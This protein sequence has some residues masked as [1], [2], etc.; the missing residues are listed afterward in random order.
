M[1][2]LSRQ[3][4]V[5]GSQ[6]AGL[7]DESLDRGKGERVGGPRNKHHL[8]WDCALLQS[9][10]APV[11]LSSLFIGISHCPHC[12]SLM[13]WHFPHNTCSTHAGGDIAA[14]AAQPPGAPPKGQGRPPVGT[15]VAWFR[16]YGGQRA[17]QAVDRWHSLGM[18]L[19][20]P[21]GSARRDSLP[22][23]FVGRDSATL[24]SSAVLLLHSE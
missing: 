24:C 16:K 23:R 1:F 5:R 21:S 19:M 11:L 18:L 10:M 22:R 12:P 4:A 7:V 3:D 2:F 14:R 9:R 15:G 17:R 20:G 8:G 6:G 13:P